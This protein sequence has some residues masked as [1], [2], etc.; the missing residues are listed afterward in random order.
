METS[1]YSRTPLARKLGIKEN[2]S[3]L[4]VKEPAHYLKLFAEL[5]EGLNFKKRISRAEVDFIHIFCSSMSQL[6][7]SIEKYKPILKKD[8]MLWVSWPKGSSSIPTD[9]N[10][11]IIREYVL[12]QGLVDVKVC[13]IDQ[14]WSALKFVYRLKDR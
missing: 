12:S 2:Y 7:K 8:G 1:G 14:D 3:I 4:L 5:P 13:S 10:R 9:I 11:D 6:V